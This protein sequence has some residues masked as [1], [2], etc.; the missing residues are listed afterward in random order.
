MDDLIIFIADVPW[1]TCSNWWNT[2]NCVNQYERKN[3]NC[4]N[5]VI[6]GTAKKICSVAAV[7]I[8]STELT[9]PVKEFWEYVQVKLKFVGRA[10]PLSACNCHM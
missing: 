6:N 5:M 8:S 4:W 1:R 2:I 7:N 3:L 10:E 9:D